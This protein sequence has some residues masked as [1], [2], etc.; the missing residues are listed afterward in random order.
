[1]SNITK[2]SI[3]LVIVV[4]LIVGYVEF[5]KHRS[6]TSFGAV[7]SQLIEDNISYYRNN[8]GLY[9]ALPELI[10]ADVTISGGTLTMTTSN[11]A[12]STV[13][14]GCLQ[15]TATSTATPIVITFGTSFTGTTTL[16]SGLA[17]G[18]GL[19]TWSYGTCPN[20]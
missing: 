2:I 15:T 19:V 9:T 3:G 20:L 1:M 13:S 7:S 5:T 14:T 12:T 10:A 16:P 6:V 18:Q 8:G 17:N 11:T 4:L